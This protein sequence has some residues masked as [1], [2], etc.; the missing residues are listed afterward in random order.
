MG[1]SA[2]SRRCPLSENSDKPPTGMNTLSPSDAPPALLTLALVIKFYVPAGSRTLFRWIS[3][4][5]F[6]KPDIVFGAKVRYWKRETVEKWI[7]QNAAG[8]AE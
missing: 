6:P 5:K 7:E 8:G 2:Y 3:A 4:G 1:E